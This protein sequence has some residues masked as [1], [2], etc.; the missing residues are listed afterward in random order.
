[1]GRGHEQEDDRRG[2][3]HEVREDAQGFARTRRRLDHQRDGDRSQHQTIR[4]VL[5]LAGELAA[6]SPRRVLDQEAD[7]GRRGDQPSSTCPLGESAAAVSGRAKTSA[8][9]VALVR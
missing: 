2:E 3:E 4:E 9:H 7:R 8:V 6:A 1:M 5:A